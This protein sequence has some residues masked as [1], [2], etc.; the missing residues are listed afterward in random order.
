MEVARSF[1]RPVTVLRRVPEI[2][3]EHSCGVHSHGLRSKRFGS[4]TARGIETLPHIMSLTTSRMSRYLAL[5]AAAAVSVAAHSAHAQVSPR[6]PN[7]PFERYTLPN[8]LTVLLA[9]DHTTP[10]VAVEVWY[11]V[12][13]KNEQPGRTGFAHLFEHVM[14]MGSGHVP[15]GTHDRLTEGVGGN[16]NATTSNDRTDYYE[17]VPSNYLEDELWLESDRMG[18]LLDSLTQQKLDAQRD[19]VKNERRQRVD[20]QPYGRMDEIISH[21]M[22][23]EGHPYQWP[24]IGSMTDLSAASL[25]DVRHFFRLYYA[26]DNAT[27]TIAGDFTP[28]VARGWVAK[29]FGDLPHGT[30][31]T[32]PDPAPAVLAG[33]RRLTYQDRVPVPELTIAWPIGGERSR[34]AVALDALADILAGSRTARL[35]KTLVYDRQ[36]AASV[37]M[38]PDT[39]ENVGEMLLV[40]TPRRGHTLTALELAAD[41]IIAQVTRDGPTVDEVRRATAGAELS[42]VRGLESNL[43][44]AE[45]LADGEVFHQNPAYYK[46]T[47]AQ[48]HALTPADVRQAALRYLTPGRVVLS[49]VPTGDL[50]AAS[51]ADHSTEVK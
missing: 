41:S 31:I 16:N 26:P 12:G 22:Y 1:M 35:T 48:T 43:G 19:V 34:D 39:H 51:K 11:H 14:F 42:F 20:N 9:E 8:G 49:I 15:Y 23:P 17:T 38:S 37:D 36:W 32:R 47:L 33:E 21:A 3:A 2:V 27:L 7:I 30:S 18:F 10:T 29:Y 6:L 45:T 40:I 13:S 50:A 5:A 25:D 46:T 44:K 4:Q 24:V 28:T